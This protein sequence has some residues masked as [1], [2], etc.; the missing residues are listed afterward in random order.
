MSF[1]GSGVFVPPTNSF[2]QA[3]AS[4]TI[5]PDDWNTTYAD[6]GATFNECITRSGDTTITANLPMATY[7]HTGVGDASALTDYASANQ[8]VD[9]V[10][11][12]IGVS[13]AG[14][15]TYAQ[16]ATIDPGGYVTGARFIFKADVINTGAC[17][18]NVSSN[19][20]VD[21]K[22]IN[23]NDPYTGA[24]AANQ[25]VEV[26]YDGTNFVLQ[27]PS[28]AVGPVLLDSQTASASATIDFTSS[29]GVNSA[30][31]LYY[32]LEF[33]GVGL[34]AG[35]QLDVRVSQS[36]TFKSDSVYAY[37][38]VGGAVAVGTEFT[39]NS[40]TAADEDCYD[41]DLTFYLG[42]S[43]LRHNKIFGSVSL[44]NQGAINGY[45]AF[46]GSY[47]SSSG[48]AQV[49]DGVRF[50]ADSGNITTGEF[51]LYGIPR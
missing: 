17:T 24:I 23:G 35:Q 51:R 41:G 30:N 18:L 48:T 22:L 9:N 11:E 44:T 47:N 38:N 36:S 31:Y 49:V 26:I 6:I 33:W 3:V 39:L 12:Y 16:N 25:F 21:I 2:A 8:V 32:K 42:E 5:D 7:R 10:L 4:T 14:T 45:G 50:L 46:D 34:A 15:D 1:N 37:E 20:A 40:R 29:E 28:Q 27:N 13:A 43:T 19:G